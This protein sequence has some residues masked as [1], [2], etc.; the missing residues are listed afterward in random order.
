MT[1]PLQ[2]TSRLD[3]L[4]VD[5]LLISLIRWPVRSRRGDMID[6]SS[7]MVE[8]LEMLEQRADGHL[9][10]FRVWS[11][12]IDRLDRVARHDDSQWKLVHRAFG[13]LWI[14]CPDCHPGQTLVKIGLAASEATSDSRLAAKLISQ[15]A[16]CHAPS[17]FESSSSSI[18]DDVLSSSQNSIDSLNGDEALLLGSEENK[19]SQ[20]L[21]LVSLGGAPISQQAFLTGL[22]ICLCSVDVDSTSTILESFELLRDFYPIGVQAELYTLG[23][24][25]YAKAGDAENAKRILVNIQRN[26]MKQRCVSEP[27]SSK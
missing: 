9:T 2:K 16:A 7:F 3:R 20:E 18:F 17:P 25:G 23:L 19:P 24:L 21:P 11:T 8:I 22:E 6:T 15:E 1:P 4:S 10:G 13:R 27:V 12:L 14:E 5:R 26:N